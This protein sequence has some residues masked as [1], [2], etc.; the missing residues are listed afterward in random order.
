M[1][2]IVAWGPAERCAHAAAQRIDAAVDGTIDVHARRLHLLR[3]RLR[4][5]RDHHLCRSGRRPQPLQCTRGVCLRSRHMPTA[6]EQRVQLVARLYACMH[7]TH[8][9]RIH[10]WHGS[11]SGTGGAQTGEPLKSACLHGV[12]GACT[13]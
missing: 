7:Q 6:E 13:V 9:A 1:G 11:I 12:K 5:R 10:Q 3:L 8:E 4:Q 2:P